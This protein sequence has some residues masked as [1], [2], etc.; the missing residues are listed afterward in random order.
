MPR[1]L[2][3]KRK[4]NSITT[5]LMVVLLILVAQLKAQQTPINI[6]IAVTPPYNANFEDYV[7]L[8]A[9][10]VIINLTCSPTANGIQVFYL[11]GT[12]SQTGASSPFSIKA[13]ELPQP[14]F[15]YAITMSPGSY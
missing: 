2:F 1:N 8:G 15:S 5:Y 4:L 10:N 13:P 14:N 12:L 6:S 11:A 9:D 7:G 3:I